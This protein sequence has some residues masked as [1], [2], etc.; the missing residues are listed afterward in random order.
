MEQL[1]H[2]QSLP[3]KLAISFRHRSWHPTTHT[4]EHYRA[5]IT[6]NITME[7]TELCI[8]ICQDTFEIQRELPN[9]TQRQEVGDAV[10]KG[11]R[12]TGSMQGCHNLQCVN[13]SVSAKHN[14]AIRVKRGKP[15]FSED[16]TYI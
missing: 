9:V 2:T 7:N 11:P 13:T 12:E 10:G 15:A 8:E 1:E 16:E 14:E 6:K 4:V 3:I 5:P